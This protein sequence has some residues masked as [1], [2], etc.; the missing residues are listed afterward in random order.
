MAVYFAYDRSTVGASE[1]SKVETLADFLEEHPRYYV[2]IEGH[3]DERGSDEYNR[4]LGERRAL[5]VKEYLTTLGI[6][7][8]RIRTVS[9]GEERPAV[10]DATTEAKHALNRRAEFLLGVEE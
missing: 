9:Y 6:A 2:V 7:G 5:A 1:R 10:P 3:C 4:A 8:D